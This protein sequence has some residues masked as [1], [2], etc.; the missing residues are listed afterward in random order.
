LSRMIDGTRAVREGDAWRLFDARVFDVGTG[1]LTTY[2]SG[3]VGAGVE[4]REFTLSHVSA[5]EQDFRTLRRSINALMIAGR[6]T[7]SLEADLWHKIAGPMSA[8]LMP[9]LAGVA[10]FGLARSGQLFLRAVAGMI[11]GF[12]YFVVDNFAL[13][14]GNLGAYPPLIAACAPFA[15]FLLIGETVLIRTEE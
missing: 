8:V 3:I 7:A 4:P 11:L 13:A 15:L 5:D 10:A 9:L 6:P 12:A 2:R 1:K 14:M